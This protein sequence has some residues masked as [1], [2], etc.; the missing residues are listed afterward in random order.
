MKKLLSLSQVLLIVLLLS[1]GVMAATLVFSDSFESGVV[2]QAPSGW[3]LSHG[4]A[5]VVVD[6]TLMSISDGTKA[7]KLVN[8]PDEYGRI[9]QEYPA[10]TKGKLMV[11]FYQDS[12]NRDNINIEIHNGVGRIVG[13]FVTG[14]GNIRVRDAGVQSSN[15]SN[16]PNDRWHTLVITWDNT[17]FSVYSLENGRDVVII[18]NCLVD[19]AGGNDPSNKVQLDVTKR[20]DEKVVYYDNVRVYDLGK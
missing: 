3:T 4:N 10:V 20:D 1:S 13:V 6:G 15:V 11:D 8:S 17:M 5:A 7:V 2:G 18:E 19:P 14:S 9:T 12:S 16:L